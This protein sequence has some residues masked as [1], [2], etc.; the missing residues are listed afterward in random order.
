MN[1]DVRVKL[2]NAAGIDTVEFPNLPTADASQDGGVNFQV[3]LVLSNRQDAGVTFVGGVGI[4]GR[5]HK[6][7][8]NPLLFPTT[9]IEYDAGGLSGTAG[10]GIKSNENLHFEGRVELDLGAGKPHNAP[11]SVDDDGYAAL[12][13][14]FGG[15][16]TF[17][18]PGLQLG[19]EL[20]V[21]SFTGEFQIW[22]FPG[23]WADGKVKGSGG[24]ANLVVGCRF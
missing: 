5:T 16:Y 1:V 2:G 14:I 15:Y 20:G 9:S 24:I 12:E 22:S 11:Y 19:L 4:F 18:K 17:G 13:L 3:E 10:I 6:G 21:Q 23:Y 7:N 8:T